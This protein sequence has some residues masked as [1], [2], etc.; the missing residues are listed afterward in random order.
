MA[1]GDRVEIVAT[2][3]WNESRKK[4]I[5]QYLFSC[6]MLIEINKILSHTCIL[7]NF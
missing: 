5:V 4:K 1:L 3:S 6:K 2:L 7:K